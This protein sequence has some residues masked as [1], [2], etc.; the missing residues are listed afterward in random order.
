MI[1]LILSLKPFS[2]NAKKWF[3]LNIITAFIGNTLILINPF[4]IGIAVDNIIGQGNVDI[5]TVV[6]YLM[7]IAIFYVVGTIL[8][9]FSQTFSHNYATIVTKNLRNEAFDTITHTP[10][11]YLDRTQTG[12]VMARFSQDIDLVFDA[13]SHFFMY[14]F[15]GVTTILIS[16]SFMLYLNIWL[17]LV[18]LIM[19]PMMMLY[20]NAT[21]KKR[22]ERFVVLQKL[23]GDLTGT[24]KEYIDEK[25]LIQ[26][27][28]YQDKAKADFDKINEE[29]TVV[30]EKAYYT[31]SINNPTYRLLN[32]I[33]YAL[34]GLVSIILTIN[35]HPVAAG[36][37]TS[38]IM[39]SA[40]FSRPFNDF[41]SLT[42][43]F[44]AG[45]AGLRRIN[46][47][48]E[49]HVEKESEEFD[50]SKRATEGNIT[51]SGVDFAYRPDQ[52][53]VKNFKMEVVKG[54]KV[55]IVGP[56]GAGKSTMINLLMRYYDVNSGSITLDGKDI[57][58]YNRNSLRLSFGL[59]LQEPWLFNGTIEANLK[60]GKHDATDEEMIKAAKQANCHDF[61]MNLKDGYKTK[62]GDSSNLSVGQRQLLTIARALII[63][64]PILILDE[65]TSNIDTLMELEIQNTFN[66]I[67]KNKTSFIIAHRLKTIV[68]ADIIIAM[69]KGNIVE[70]GTHK[71]LMDNEGFYSK[72]YLSQFE[73]EI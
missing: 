11:A 16:V 27:Y 57:R 8:L 71:E 64:P 3:I 13:I 34:L 54:Q 43:N 47:V 17:T 49:L 58:D 9:W 72:L 73:K 29:L 63:D 28:N 70:F 40:M 31:A 2:K 69:D 42:A 55:A 10:V 26:A 45:R 39:Y 33:S 24:A 19:V 36:V 35:G 37:L 59:V 5:K 48:L 25:K 50:F 56:T 52:S 15:Q 14:F 44:M 66:R 20:S 12:D 62:L 4:L 23:I 1:E 7:L 53:L 21:K 67:M 38:M 18:V 65:A 6:F 41:S 60:Y 61:I 22:N 32:N 46:E 68:D 30:G 51:F